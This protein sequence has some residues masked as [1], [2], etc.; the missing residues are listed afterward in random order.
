MRAKETGLPANR[1]DGLDVG[2]DC[3]VRL[4]TASGNSEC[5][6]GTL[7]NDAQASFEDCSSTSNG[8]GFVTC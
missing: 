5:G 1:Y 8:Y 7:G 2:H 4:C 6:F 3:L